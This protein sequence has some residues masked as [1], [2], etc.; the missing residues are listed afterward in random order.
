M[1]NGR[2]G[3]D[4]KEAPTWVI[5]TITDRYMEIAQGLAHDPQVVEPDIL[6]SKRRAC[7]CDGLV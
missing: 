7:D 4:P 1:D 6:A 3:A 5:N 2:V